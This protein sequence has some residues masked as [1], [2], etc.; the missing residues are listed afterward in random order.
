MAL[1]S[2][3]L[4]T[5]GSLVLQPTAASFS[6]THDWSSSPTFSG[7][8]G[9]VRIGK[10]G[11][12]G[13]DQSSADIKVSKISSIGDIA[14]YGNTVTLTGGLTTSETSGNGIL[15]KAVNDIITSAGT[16]SARIPITVT[17][18]NSSAPIWLWA[19]AD[20]GTTASN[21]GAVAIANYTDITTVDGPI[22]IGGGASSGEASPSGYALST[23]TTS[24]ASACNGI[25]IGTSAVLDIVRITSTTGNVTLK[26]KSLV[27]KANCLGIKSWSGS[28]YNSG[29]GALT[30]D[31][32]NVAPTGSNNG[33]GIEFNWSGGA[34]TTL[35]SAKD[36]GTAI[37]ITG[38]V[39][40]A[41]SSASSN[42]QGV[43][44]WS[45][46]GAQI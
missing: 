8:F 10:A 4:K 9:S 18:A 40:S 32:Y 46:S 2:T 31:G 1:S 34:A 21:G 45:A 16:S 14:I 44:V 35:T 37:S 24:G 38:Y 20:A 28:T 39:S 11:T 29:N 27:D 43:V 33:H 3:T 23:S 25:E 6:K 15:V 19:N 5:S 26:G 42:G 30:F 13:S 7:T 36:T 17:G 41:S 22:Y 12:G